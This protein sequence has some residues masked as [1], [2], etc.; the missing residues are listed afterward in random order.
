[1]RTRYQ[2]RRLPVKVKLTII[3][4]AT[5][6]LALS[7][8]TAAVLVYLRAV[9]G[10]ATGNDLRVLA[11]MYATNSAAA[12]TFGD[13]A[14]A[15]ELLAGFSA[16]RSIIAAIIY[17]PDGTPFA[18]YRRRDSRRRPSPGIAVREPVLLDAQRIGTLYLECDLEDVAAILDRATNASLFI[19]FAAF[20][21]AILLGVKL[22]RSITEPIRRLAEVAERVS[23]NRDYALRAPRVS[24]DELGQLTLR[25]NNMLAEIQ[26]RDAQL[27]ANQDRLEQKVAERT[28]ELAL[29]KDQ[30]EHACVALDK[31]LTQLS[32]ALDGANEALWDCDIAGNRTYYS[33][34]WGAMLGFS[35]EEIGERVEIWDRLLHPEDRGTAMKALQEHI[36][37]RTETYETEYR[38]RT[39]DGD[40]R[41]IQARG[42][43]VQRGS[44]GAAT[45]IA[46][47]HL[48]ITQRKTAEQA[49]ARQHN[50]LESLIESVPDH[51][52]FKDRESR[53]IRINRAQSLRFGLS[54]PAEAVGKT[55]FDFFGAKHAESARADELDLIEG[56]QTTITKEEKEDWPDGR[57]TWVQTNKLPLRDHSGEIVGTLG[58]SR[59]ITER[60]RMED[61]LLLAKEKAEAANRAKSEFLAN[62]SHEIRTP[63]NGIIG[64][65]ELA[66]DTPL[67]EQQREYL[68]TVRTSGEALLTIINDI[69]DFS[70][71]EAGKMV[72]ERA[73]FDL[74]P[75]LQDALRIVSVQAHRKGLE[76]LYDCK[77]DVSRPVAGD[78]AK[79]R[80]ILVNLLANGIKFTDSGEVKLSVLDLSED[81][82]VVNAHFAV[83]DTGIGIADSAKDQ[84]FQAFVQADGSH[85]RRYGGTGLGLTICSRLAA[86][87]G[88]RVWV[89]SE[90]GKGS[91]FHLTV[92]LGSSN[93]S[94]VRH[95]E[96]GTA[97]CSIRSL[98]VL[99][100]EDNP[101]N[102][103]VAFLLLK[104]EGHSVAE[105][106]NGVEAVAA[107]GRENFDIVLMDVQMPEMDGY[108]ATKEIRA[109]ENGTG[110]HV[111][112][113]A[114]TAHAMSGAR[115][116]CLSAGM[117]DYLSKPIAIKE[118]REV[119]KKWTA[120]A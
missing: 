109:R 56:R 17:G 9:L 82:G 28:A 80:Q 32:L 74:D 110:T 87:M 23:A 44:D 11:Q 114:L 92:G 98:R 67:D 108:D 99:L 18:A 10:A 52:Y 2:Y 16:K 90:A 15:T 59:D 51:I 64:M 3:I 84:I 46:G 60:K 1:M 43:V 89:E 53:F 6:A 79:L 62:M 66:L 102:R 93:Q 112:I 39:K 113:V 50:I 69:L 34:R 73:D 26:Q 65:A 36:A 94:P 40:W 7:V 115:E 105:A 86:L 76:L 58:I 41:W 22:Q 31:S 120:A 106:S 63:M 78:A 38:M 14:A 96:E 72:L 49:L 21:V 118:L 35:K 5:V 75:V 45:R 101:V 57:V 47:T 37:G 19:L 61:A 12:L 4:F 119:L 29:A 77:V 42:R 81:D 24:D 117:D 70:K 107:M 27:L 103:R 25:F 111:P 100:A 104:R 48:D 55:D 88:G 20:G 116:I 8:S 13:K 85:S 83:S 30:A 54:E 33:E 95:P 91:T 97:Q 71:I 68:S